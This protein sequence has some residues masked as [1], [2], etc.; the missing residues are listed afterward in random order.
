M[1][2]VTSPLLQQL[3]VQRAD[4]RVVGVDAVLRRASEPRCPVAGRGRAKLDVWKDSE[5]YNPT[6]PWKPCEATWAR[7]TCMFFAVSS[8]D[9]GASSS[10]FLR[11]KSRFILVP[12]RFPA[13]A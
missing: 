3:L 12:N 5:K 4:S 11:P 9:T 7:R 10:F 2:S 1:P 8:R 13:T 6:T